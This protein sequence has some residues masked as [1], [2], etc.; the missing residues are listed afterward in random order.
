MSRTIIE[1]DARDA[2]TD[3][4]T[5][6]M[7]VFDT[8]DT[9]D[10]RLRDA[11]AQALRTASAVHYPEEVGA[12]EIVR[13]DGNCCQHCGGELEEGFAGPCPHCAR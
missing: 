8:N 4:L 1:D 3:A 12:H 6:L 11:I 7:L 5:D 9:N 2:L 10:P 13:N